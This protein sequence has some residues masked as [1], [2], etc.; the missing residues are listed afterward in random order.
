MTVLD[1]LLLRLSASPH[2][3]VFVSG[4]P[5]SGTTAVLRLMGLAAGE[6]TCNDPFYQLD[7]QGVRFRD[8]LFA[9]TLR[10][11]GLMRTYPRVFRGTLLKDPNFVFFQRDLR[12]AWPSAAWVFTIRDPRDNVRSILNRLRLPGR[13]DG[14]RTGLERVTGAWRDVLLG[15]NPA[16]PGGDPIEHMA[17]RW[18]CIAEAIDA[19][20]DGAVVSRYEEFVRD[21]PARIA[22]LCRAVG[23]DPVHDIREQMDVPF[24]PRGD[25]QAVWEEFFGPAELATLESVCGPWLARFGY[26]ALQDTP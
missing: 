8:A 25:R 14:I 10:L 2:P 16:L 19:V 7:L 13:V 21:K 9:E 17:R 15:R 26:P 22:D 3:D 23:L 6:R 24:Q 5:K 18:V 4:M 11:P 20:G 1:R 12:D